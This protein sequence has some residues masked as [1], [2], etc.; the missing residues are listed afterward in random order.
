[1]SMTCQTMPHSDEHAVTLCP[2]L[3]P[4]LKAKEHIY[5]NTT[6]EDSRR[7]PPLYPTPYCARYNKPQEHSDDTDSKQEYVYAVVD[8]T[9]A[10]KTNDEVI[11]EIVVFR[12]HVQSGISMEFDLGKIY[13]GVSNLSIHRYPGKIIHVARNTFLHS[14]TFSNNKLL[15]M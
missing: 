3:E 1:M 13:Q 7:E 4:L 8:K 15:N 11:A 6:Q 5:E 12:S 10:K 2:T 14:G 9:R